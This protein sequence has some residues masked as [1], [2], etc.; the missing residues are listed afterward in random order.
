VSESTVRAALKT[1]LLTVSNVGQV[2]DYERWA[3]TIPDVATSFRT[4]ISGSDCIRG[5]TIACEGW[6]Q[7]WLVYNEDEAPGHVNRTYTY[8][9]RGYFGLQDST[10]TEKTA[11][12]I[13][14]DVCEALD[15]SDELHDEEDYQGRTPPAILTIFEPR[16]F[17]SI[18]CHYAEIT[19]QVTEAI[20]L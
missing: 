11:I 6:A 3:G 7:E 12:G 20:S 4:T 14:E 10:A 15:K 13:V 17:G 16:M 9:I 2:H 5:W 1:I 18:L 19:A 8:K